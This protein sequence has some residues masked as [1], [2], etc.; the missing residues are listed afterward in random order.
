MSKIEGGRRLLFTEPTPR[1]LENQQGQG[2][3]WSLNV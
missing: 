3:E 2:A 1:A